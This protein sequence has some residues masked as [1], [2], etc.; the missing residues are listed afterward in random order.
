MSAWPKP[1]RLHELGAGALELAL[2]P[3]CEQRAE[4]A[5]RLGLEGL[6]ALTADVTVLPWLDGAELSGT[7]QALVVQVCGV[8]LD[9]FEAEVA[10]EFLVRVV[11]AGSPNAAAPESGAIEIEPDAP[12]PPDELATDEIDVAGYVL[13]HLA[14]ALD[15]FP[16][17]PGA[18]FEYQP[19]TAEPS[20][21][22]ALAALK[23]P[24][25]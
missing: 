19:P 1:L 6:S 9:P 10:G 16:R 14:L 22:A 12:D 13:E 5:G 4:A 20:P 11:P 24:K 25:A 17:K 2:A 15:P 8:T 21:F 23:A 18:T 7:F 3:D